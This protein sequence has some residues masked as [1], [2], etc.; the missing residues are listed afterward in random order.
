MMS[1]RGR[2][3]ETEKEFRT[4]LAARMNT[5][6]PENYYTLVT[7]SQL[8]RAM[9]AQGQY[10]RAEAEFRNIL[11]I[12]LQLRML[13]QDHL[14]TLWTRSRS[15][16]RWQPEAITMEP[17][18]NFTRC[19]QDAS[20]ESRTTLTPSLPS[21]SSREFMQLRVTYLRPVQNLKTC[22]QRR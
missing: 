3:A 10:A 8:A 1:A 13:G 12:Q 4:I 17:I 6:G 11:A 7:R 18:T 19:R 16:R 22:R 9:G 14:R 2:Y 20:Q 15:P 21:T 5:L